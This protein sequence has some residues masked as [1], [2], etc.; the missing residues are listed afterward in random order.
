M[1][2]RPTGEISYFKDVSLSFETV[3]G[4]ALC[5]HSYMIPLSS[6]THVRDLAVKLSNPSVHCKY[7]RHFAIGSNKTLFVSRDDVLNNI[8]KKLLYGAIALIV[9]VGVLPLFHPRSLLLSVLTVRK[10]MAQA[11]AIVLLAGSYRERVPAVAMLYHN[12]YAPLI[13]LPNDGIFSSWSKIYHRNLYNVEWAE[14]GLVS[15]GVPRERIVKLPYY[16]SSTMFDAIGVKRFLLS[17]GSGIKDIIIVTNDY[18][19]RRAFWTF[20]HALKDANRQIDVYPI[21]STVPPG[22]KG[23][24]VECVKLVGYYLRYGMLGFVPDAKEIELKG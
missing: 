11:G 14:E 18:H 2:F 20:R 16:G 17:G 5:V 24:V 21:Q 3:V 9:V 8:K 15:L 19:T 1:P 7:L 4:S 23:L 13:V 22:M 6:R 10:P 12:G